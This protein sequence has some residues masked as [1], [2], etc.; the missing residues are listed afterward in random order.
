MRLGVVIPAYCEE[1]N[2]ALLCS[3]ISEIIPSVKILVVDDSPNTLSVA[4][5]NNLGIPNVRIIHRSAKSG[6][7]SAV[8]FGIAELL[9]SEVDS[10]L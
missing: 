2:I 5:I 10:V 6:R 4:A 9:K 1:E 8:L 7:G 3:Q